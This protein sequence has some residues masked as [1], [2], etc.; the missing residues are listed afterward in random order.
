MSENLIR[1][2][3]LVHNKKIAPSREKA[4]EYI[5]E[6]KIY[7]NGLKEV[8][9]GKKIHK[10]SQIEL[11]GETIPYVSRGG[12]KLEKA[13]KSFNIDLKDKICLDIGASTGGFTHCMLKEGATKVYS[14][15]VGHDQLV[16]ELKEDNRVISMEG[17]NARYLTSEDFEELSDFASID[18]SFISLEKIIP[19]VTNL[20]NKNGKII[21]LI[22]PQFEVGRGKV[23]KKGVVKKVTDH[24]EVIFRIVKF[25]ESIG[26]TVLG[27][28]YS[29]IKGP[30]G[31]IEYLV[32]F[33][34]SI[35]TNNIFSVDEIERIAKI[36]HSSLSMEEV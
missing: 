33:S 35:N 31:N 20:L 9:C 22:K 36:S 17:V 7:V 25:I 8:K 29:P 15:D 18:V 21:A 2:D 27:L 6:G 3:I 11:R 23:N 16:K 12:L 1:L 34:K 4:K 28:D 13:I 10:D 24:I 14:I 32:Y 5:N 26:L 19:S 30:N